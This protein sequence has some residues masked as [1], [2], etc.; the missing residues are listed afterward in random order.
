M[1]SCSG[2]QT[3]GRPSGSHT[4]G[5]RRKAAIRAAAAATLTV[6]NQ[7]TGNPSRAKPCRRRRQLAPRHAAVTLDRRGI[8]AHRARNGKGK[9]AVDIAVALDLRPGE[10]LGL[11][12]AGQR[13]RRRVE[14]ARRHRAEIDRFGAIGSGA[15]HDHEADAAEPAVPGF[16]DSERQRGRDG[17]V[18]RGAARGQYLGSDRGGGAVLRGDDAALGRSAGLADLPVLAQV[19]CRGP[20]SRP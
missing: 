5:F 8:T 15:M 2:G 10:Q 9:R 11:G 6:V 16:E 12:G 3:G 20:L 7:S 4:G 18:D 17:G 1:L 13:K 19:H 14:H